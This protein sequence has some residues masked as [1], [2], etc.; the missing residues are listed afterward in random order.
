MVGEL[1]ILTGCETTGYE[2][3]TIGIIV[4]LERLGALYTIYWV[5]MP[6]DEEIP[7][8]DSEFEVIS[9]RRRPDNSS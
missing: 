3:G 6:D 2:D 8:W 5:L 9:D 1:V 4:K 7:M